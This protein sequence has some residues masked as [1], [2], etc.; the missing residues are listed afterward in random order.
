MAKIKLGARPKNFNA[1]VNVKLLD[2]TDG[3]IEMKF[4]YRTRT[5]FG[6][7][8]DEIHAEN[9]ASTAASDEDTSTLLKRAYETGVD[10]HAGQIMRAAEGWNLDEDFSLENIKALCDELPG[11]A[12]AIMESY[13]VAIT[14]G[15]LGN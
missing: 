12:F 11:V 10:R 14:E 9:G 4:K 13:R 5:E 1:T 6:A 2:G 3:A 8:L 15:R 7:F